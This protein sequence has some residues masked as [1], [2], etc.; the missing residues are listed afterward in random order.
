MTFQRLQKKL[1]YAKPLVLLR[2]F[3][4]RMHI[5]TAIA[6]FPIKNGAVALRLGREESSS[7]S[8]KK[9]SSS[10]N[11]LFGLLLSPQWRKQKEKESMSQKETFTLPLLMLTTREIHREIALTQSSSSSRGAPTLALRTIALL[12]STKNETCNDKLLLCP[13][14]PTAAGT[15]TSFMMQKPS[16]TKWQLTKWSVKPFTS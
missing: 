3:L 11:F 10:G 8:S 4:H 7:S 5:A 13:A 9:S 2:Q 14:A 15:D 1:S 16:Y 6:I 12:Q